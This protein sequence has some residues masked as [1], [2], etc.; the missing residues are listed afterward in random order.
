MLTDRVEHSRSTAKTRRS[1]SH[2]DATA[3]ILTHLKRSPLL[4]SVNLSVL[5]GCL[6]A[7][8]GNHQV[9][10][11]ICVSDFR[12]SRYQ[13]WY[14]VP[15]CDCLE[16]LI[17][18]YTCYFGNLITNFFGKIRPIVDQPLQASISCDGSNLNCAA[19]CAAL[20][21]RC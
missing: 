17:W 6:V 7:Y 19:F 15:A 16:K 12:R 2:P 5:S 4:D 14:L 18:W 13:S 8:F 9:S 20:L 1:L 11:P 10:F 3:S 21:K